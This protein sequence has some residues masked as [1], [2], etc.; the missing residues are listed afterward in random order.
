M[1]ARFAVALAFVLVLAAVSS[2]GASSVAAAQEE[3]VRATMGR[4]NAQL[5]AQ[6]AN[7][8]LEVIETY[9]DGVN[10]MGI[11]VFFADRGNKQLPDHWV[12]ADPRRG[13]FGDI[14]YITD[15]VDGATSSGLTAADTTAAIDAAMA[16][17][18]A[19][20]CSAI[21][22]TNLGAYAFDLGV[23]QYLLGYGGYPGWFAD[24]TQAGFLPSSFFD[25]LQP[26]G[27]SFI[28]GA[29]LTFVWLDGGD[30]TDINNDGKGDVAF[31]EVYYNDAFPWAIGSTYDVETVVLHEAGHG[32]S[33]DHFGA[34]FLSPN[35]RL[36]FAPRALM[37]AVY[38]GVQRT[39]VGT[40]NAGHCSIWASWPNQ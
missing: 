35:G 5:A 7:Y 18:D 26:G 25:L 23:A 3:A 8:R 12:P 19:Q 33:Q 1:H 15:L 39:V 32:L 40:D 21:P 11:T 37:N 34:A 38:S 29:T 20:V 30:P 16:T 24:F 36:H 4:I 13:G 27:G 9:G 6:N 22:I 14:A 31:R 10:G 2:G 17:W 28:L